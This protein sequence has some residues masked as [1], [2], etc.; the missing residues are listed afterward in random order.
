MCIDLKC[1]IFFVLTISK[2]QA[3]TYSL[4]SSRMA[5]MKEETATQLKSLEERILHMWR[6]L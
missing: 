6:Y 1:V 5:P 4:L 3:L 2:S